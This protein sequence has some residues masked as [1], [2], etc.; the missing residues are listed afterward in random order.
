MKDQ[1]QEWINSNVDNNCLGQCAEVTEAMQKA[2]PELTRVR[3]H[4]MCLV[5]GPRAHWWL[6]DPDGEIVDPTV[7]QF[8]TAGLAAPS[9]YEPW[10]ES[11][12]EP[13]GM[14]PNCGGY[15]YDGYDLC[16]D[17]CER[18]YIAYLNNPNEW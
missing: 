12:P 6:V 9:A 7:A 17:E 13:T 1:Y 2:F 5:W 3:G 11:E 14:C 16:S 10:D 15:C 8:P 18:A 4:F